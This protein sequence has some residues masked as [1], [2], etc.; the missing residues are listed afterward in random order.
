[1]RLGMPALRLVRSP[2]SARPTLGEADSDERSLESG[3]RDRQISRLDCAL[4]DSL[5]LAA[6][7]LGPL[8][9]DLGGH[10]GHLRQNHDAVRSNLQEAAEDGELLLLPAAFEA[11]HAL[12]ERRDQRGV[13]RE[14]AKLAFAA[15]DD[16]L[17]HIAHE[18][19]FLRSDYFEVKRH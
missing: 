16:D 18:G 10:V 14:Y 12:A 17:V 7:A 2:R 8:E 19:P 15:R 6:G 13:V 1:M 5:G 11:Q 4:E 3:P 9:V